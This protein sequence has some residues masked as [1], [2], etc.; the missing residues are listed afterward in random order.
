MNFLVR[1]TGIAPV[2][3]LLPR[4]AARYLTLCLVCFG[5]GPRNRTGP[6]S[7]SEA[8]RALSPHVPEVVGLAGIEP[9]VSSSRTKRITAFLQPE[10]FFG[11]F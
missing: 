8:A 7:A 11:E 5:Q 1:H 3:L 10:V 4:Q 2:Y 6:M 9:A